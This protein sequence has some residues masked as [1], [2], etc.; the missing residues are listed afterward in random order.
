M[1][2]PSGGVL[3]KHKQVSDKVLDNI[4]VVG[5]ASKLDFQLCLPV[6]LENARLV[7]VA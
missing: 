2:N 6:N 7:V 1:E 3:Q 5:P 4:H